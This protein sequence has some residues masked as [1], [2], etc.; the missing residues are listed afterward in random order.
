MSSE[1]PLVCVVMPAFRSAGTLSAAVESVLIQR[2]E[3]LVLAIALQPRDEDTIAAAE[4]F[5]DARVRIVYRTGRGIANAR[6]SAIRSVRADYY[7]F[8]DSD[9]EYSGPDVVDAYV[10]DIRRHP[11]PALRFA[12]WVGVSGDDG[13]VRR[14]R[15]AG[16]WRPT[17]N[18]LLLDNFVATGTV[19]LPREVLDE[20]GLFDERYRHAEDWDLWLRAA[21]R[22]PIRH[23]PLVALHYRETKLGVPYPRSHFT[24]EMEIVARQPGGRLLRVSALATAYGRH[25]LYFV[26]TLRSRRSA[27][28]LLALR[29]VDV[30]CI[31]VVAAY[32]AWRSMSGMRRVRLD[33]G[34][35]QGPA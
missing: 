33:A 18:R 20:V 4:R 12:D 2:Y 29:P 17:F 16:R 8:L 13:S 32:K 14:A 11:D 3:R 19:M 28:A 30:L 26:R 9:D 24:S 31:P 35:A 10:E 21:Y 6:N 22:Y 27:S 34:P 15:V 23:V 1:A 5:S 7:M 25:G